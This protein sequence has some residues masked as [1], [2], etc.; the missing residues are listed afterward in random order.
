[1]NEKVVTV[2]FGKE[3]R[4]A[5]RKLTRLL[6]IVRAQEDELLTDPVRL[7][8]L[9]Q[10]AIAQKDSLIRE[11]RDALRPR[12]DPTLPSEPVRFEPIKTVSVM[13][14]EYY[15][16]KAAAEIICRDPSPIGEEG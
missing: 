16:L 12:I 5:G 6:G 9:A 2:N 14:D 11:A 13:A 1:M 4:E 15:R 10:Q 3:A 8:D 7:F